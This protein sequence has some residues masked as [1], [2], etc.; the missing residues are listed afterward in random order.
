VCRTKEREKVDICRPMPP[1]HE[2]SVKSEWQI[3]VR[4]KERGF[5]CTAN[6]RLVKAEKRKKKVR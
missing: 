3:I 2:S 6:E 1:E 4:E 5:R